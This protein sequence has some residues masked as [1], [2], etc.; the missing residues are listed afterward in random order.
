MNASHSAK[1][2][3]FHSQF[4]DYNDLDDAMRRKIGVSICVTVS[5][6]YSVE[7]GGYLLILLWFVWEYPKNRVFAANAK[8]N[9]KMCNMHKITMREMK[10][11][12]VNE[13]FA[14]RVINQT[15][16]RHCDI[17][18]EFRRNCVFCVV[19]LSTMIW[20]RFYAKFCLRWE[21]HG[22][23]V[24]WC[25]NELVWFL[26]CVCCFGSWETTA[27]WGQLYIVVKKRKKYT[28]Q[29]VDCLLCLAF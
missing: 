18:F 15:N 19:G 25:S 20:H 21:P 23:F 13:Y 4:T 17:A 3:E 14:S 12:R 5:P 10:C 11:A 7:Y 9:G 2:Y 27:F 26:M 6:W 16:I 24:I 22:W 8:W 29:F 28:H 1:V